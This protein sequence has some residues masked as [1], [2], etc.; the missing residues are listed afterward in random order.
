MSYEKVSKVKNQTIIGVKQTMKAM[1]HGQVNKVFVAEDADRSLTQK[2]EELA[3]T[4]GIPVERVDSKKKLGAACGIS[5]SASTVA[6][7]K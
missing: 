6:I 1:K 5:V 7:K 2:V 3:E 4:L